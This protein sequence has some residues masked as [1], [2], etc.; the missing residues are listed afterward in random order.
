[1]TLAPR[2]LGGPKREGR[3]DGGK[4]QG[5]RCGGK[6]GDF[7]PLPLPYHPKKKTELCFW[8]IFLK[9]RMGWMMMNGHGVEV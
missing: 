6:R 8:D 5:T 4:G 9:L 2:R 3:W 1:M 7:I